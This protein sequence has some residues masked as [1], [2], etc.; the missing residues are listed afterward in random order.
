MSIEKMPEFRTFPAP[1][2]LERLLSWI[3][4]KIYKI[5]S[6]R[7]NWLLRRVLSEGFEFIVEGNEP[8]DDGNWRIIIISG[9]LQYQK[10]VSSTWVNAQKIAGS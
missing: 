2:G 8:G 5:I 3:E 4:N 9:D 1:K 7:I 10:R 6:R